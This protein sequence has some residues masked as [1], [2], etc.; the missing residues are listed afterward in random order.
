MTATMKARRALD[1]GLGFL[2]LG[3]AFACPMVGERAAGGVNTLLR[4]AGW[5]YGVQF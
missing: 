5:R 2:L 3:A 1:R 4:L